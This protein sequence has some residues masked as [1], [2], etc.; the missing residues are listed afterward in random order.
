MEHTNPHEPETVRLSGLEIDPHVVRLIPREMAQRFRLVAVGQ[1]D[2]ALVLA[3]EDPLDVIATDTIAANTGY[4]VTLYGVA[5]GTAS[6]E[7]VD[8]SQFPSLD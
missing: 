5:G 1:E 3:M 2:D 7:N 8:P 6:T 4:E